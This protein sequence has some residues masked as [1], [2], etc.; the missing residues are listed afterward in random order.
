MEPSDKDEGN[1]NNNNVST[2]EDEDEMEDMDQGTEHFSSFWL[3]S[4]S[5]SQT[6]QFSSISFPFSS[7]KSC[8][9]ILDTWKYFLLL[10]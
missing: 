3:F 1:E 7:V 6:I 10:F 2:E 4:T 8:Q 5:T 9:L